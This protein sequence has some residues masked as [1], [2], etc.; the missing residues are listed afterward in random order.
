M[1]EVYEFIEEEYQGEQLYLRYI[2][3]EYAIEW[4]DNPKEHA[5]S[6]IVESIRTNGFGDP[7]KWDKNLNNGEGGLVFGN[8]RTHGLKWMKHNREKAPRGILV[9]RETGQWLI[10]VLFGIDAPS[11]AAA[12]RFAL[13]HNNLTLAGGDLNAYDIGRLYDPVKYLDI[14]DRLQKQDIMPI[15]VDSFDLTAL[16][17]SFGKAG[18]FVP[19]VPEIQAASIDI[20]AAQAVLDRKANQADSDGGEL[21]GKK[22]SNSVD[23]RWPVVKAR[24]RP[25]LYDIFIEVTDDFGET[26]DE[27]F[28]GLLKQYQIARRSNAD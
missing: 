14:L 18:S 26:D 6:D 4:E 16:K 11:L 21:G 13:D 23:E 2:P 25:D 22:T 19:D 17:T 27:R 5:I 12:E 28:E 9:H 8:G 20:A 7:P 3:L 24:V 10:P 1:T 15:T